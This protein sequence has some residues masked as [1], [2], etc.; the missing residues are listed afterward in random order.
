MNRKMS[1]HET[2]K[3]WMGRVVI[4]V[5]IIIVLFPVLWIVMSSFSAGDSFFLSSLF[6]KKF[7]IEHYTSLFQETNFK[8]HQ[9]H[10]SD[11]IVFHFCKKKP[12]TIWSAASSLIL[13]NINLFSDS[14]QKIRRT[15]IIGLQFAG[16]VYLI[17]VELVAACTIVLLPT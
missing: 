11:N 1:P 14:H 2:R 6:P 13:Y 17:P 8:L 16:D 15:E 4:W 9:T 5:T 10:N 12:Q 3:L 7:S